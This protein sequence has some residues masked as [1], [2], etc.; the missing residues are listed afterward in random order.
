[1]NSMFLSGFGIHGYKSRNKRSQP[2]EKVRIVIANTF[3]DFIT[4]ES[5]FFDLNIIGKICV[6]I[7]Q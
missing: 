2:K 1:M 3:N 7:N 6:L 4:V 5:S